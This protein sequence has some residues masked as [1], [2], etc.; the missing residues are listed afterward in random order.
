VILDAPH[1]LSDVAG[2]VVQAEGVFSTLWSVFRRGMGF[3]RTFGDNSFGIFL[4]GR[5]IHDYKYYIKRSQTQRDDN[6]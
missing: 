5:F 3:N 1:V 6:D 2:E 4:D